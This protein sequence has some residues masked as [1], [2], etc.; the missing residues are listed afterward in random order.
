MESTDAPTPAPVE[1]PETH[2]VQV[3]LL[4]VAM[5]VVS[6]IMWIGVPLG[7]LWIAA[8]VSSDYQTI[9][10]W[11]LFAIPVTMVGVGWVLFRLNAVYVRVSNEAD[12]P[13]QTTWLRS[14]AADRSSSEP[15]RA[16]DIIMACS[17]GLA[18]ALLAL[19]FF[20]FAGS[21]L[22]GAG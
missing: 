17:V 21:P 19:W 1:Q 11:A 13:R 20:V 5:S 4:I 22:P 16:I 6:L 8:Q 10:L 18:V 14:Q 9:Y 7:W 15:K 12:G 3:V 2:R